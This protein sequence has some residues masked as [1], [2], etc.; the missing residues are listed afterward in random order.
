MKKNV[1]KETCC[2]VIVLLTCIVFNACSDKDEPAVVPPIKITA[3]GGTEFVSYSMHGLIRIPVTVENSEV[4]PEPEKFRYLDYAETGIEDLSRSQEKTIFSIQ[5]VEQGEGGGYVL[6]AE[7][8]YPTYTSMVATCTLTYEGTNTS[9][10]LKLTCYD[11]LHMT[12]THLGAGL[13]GLLKF[14]E[15]EEAYVPGGIPDDLTVTA[16]QVL[17]NR[18]K[19]VSLEIDKTN[20]CVHITLNEN[21]KFTPEEEERGYSSLMLQATMSNGVVTF[22]LNNALKICPSSILNTETI[23]TD[24]VKYNWYVEEAAKA[25]GMDADETGNIILTNRPIEY[26]IA[27]KGE[28]LVPTKEFDVSLFP[29]KGGVYENDGIVYFPVISLHGINNLPSGEYVFVAHAKKLMDENDNQYVDI[30]MPFV[31]E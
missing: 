6:I 24:E 13:S 9:I 8:N 10:P 2:W 20:N 11:A 26:Y 23:S 14:E 22:Y 7:Y 29:S 16:I 1:W 3:T 25:L 30:R 27:R 18:D 17:D 5:S 12:T 28:P 4:K 19:D 15:N 31:K 21:F